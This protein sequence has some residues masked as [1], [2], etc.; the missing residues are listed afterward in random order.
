MKLKY[1]TGIATFIQFVAVSLLALANQINAIIVGCIQ[2][3]SG[4]VEDVIPSVGYFLVTV[5]VFAGI[6]TLG[7]FAQ[8]RRSRWLALGLVGIELLVIKVAKHNAENHTDLLSLASSMINLVL[9]AYIIFL[10][11]RLIRSKGG[12]VVARQSARRR[13]NHPTTEL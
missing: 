6:W 10:A 3:K 2:H 4:C 13:R 9:A 7:Y 5:V 11:I 1:E 8:E 12:R